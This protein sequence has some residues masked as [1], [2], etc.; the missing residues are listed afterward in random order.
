MKKKEY[1]WKETLPIVIYFSSP[2]YTITIKFR[3]FQWTKLYV[4]GRGSARICNN[5]PWDGITHFLMK[6]HELMAHNQATGLA[7]SSLA[8]AELKTPSKAESACHDWSERKRAV[9][10]GQDC[11]SL[12]SYSLH[13]FLGPAGHS[14]GSS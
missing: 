14:S 11:N 13:C 1:C 8:S 4:G 5:H 7:D 12:L 9:R 3:Y 6:I 10:F 2:F